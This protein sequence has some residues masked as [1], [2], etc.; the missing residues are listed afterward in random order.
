MNSE[1]VFSPYL[2]KHVF[3]KITLSVYVIVLALLGVLF[4]LY[5]W[6][7][8]VNETER[9][10]ISLAEAAEAGIIKSYLLE[11]NADSSDIGKSEYEELKSNLMAFTKL[12]NDIRFA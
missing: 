7:L 10:A 2:R 11:L 1:V 12:D 4:I 6:N 8:S 9:N 5:T 3:N